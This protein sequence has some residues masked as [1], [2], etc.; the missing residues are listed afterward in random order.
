MAVAVM[1]PRVKKAHCPV[2]TVKVFPSLSIQQ[3]HSEGAQE[4]RGKINSSYTSKK[5]VIDKKEL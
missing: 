3:L 4:E 5:A 2:R 1:V